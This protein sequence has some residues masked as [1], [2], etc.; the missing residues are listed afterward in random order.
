MDA[1]FVDRYHAD[2]HAV[3]EVM[4]RLNKGGMLC[5][6]PEGTRSP[7]GALIRPHDGAAYLAMKAGVPVV[8]AA[9]T[10]TEDRKVLAQLKRF[11]RPAITITLGE[12]FL[13]P[14]LPKNGRDA[15]VAA[16]TEEIMLRIAELLPVEYRGIYADHPGLHK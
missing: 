12:P 5:L 2:I 16:F 10:G 1:I 7:T 13:P 9:F 11:R 14:P 6:A 4:R 15:A 3:R 8:P